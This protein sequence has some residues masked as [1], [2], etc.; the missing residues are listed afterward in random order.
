[1]TLIMLVNDGAES[2][3]GTSDWPVDERQLS[4]I[5]LVDHVENGLLLNLV[6]LGVKI[7]LLRGRRKLIESI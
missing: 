5:V 1:M 7:V 4:N 2:L 6:H 3:F